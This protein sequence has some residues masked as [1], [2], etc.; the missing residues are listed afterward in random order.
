[1]RTLIHECNVAYSPKNEDKADYNIGWVPRTPDDNSTV[2]P[3][4][5]YKDASALDGY[6]FLT[7]HSL[8]NGGGYV[9]ELRGDRNALFDKLAS[10]K[11]SGW[12]DKYTRAVFLE[13][14]IYNVQ[15]NM[16]ACV[17][18]VAELIESSGFDCYYYIEPMNLLGD[19]TSAKIFVRVCQVSAFEN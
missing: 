14:S 9:A 8:Y 19:M 5:H 6:P 11:Q 18:M 12:I 15:S 2:L 3:E 17:T 4:Y 1:M 10:L 16:F 7:R 13:F